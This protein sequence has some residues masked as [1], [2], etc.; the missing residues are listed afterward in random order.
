MKLFCIHFILLFFRRRSKY[1]RAKIWAVRHGRGF[2]FGTNS[3]TSFLLH[4]RAERRP[5]DSKLF[6]AGETEAVLSM[7]SPA[8]FVENALDLL[9]RCWKS[10]SGTSH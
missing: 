7:A 9:R 1:L 8:I 10:S 4:L 2:V 3:V 5:F 6:S